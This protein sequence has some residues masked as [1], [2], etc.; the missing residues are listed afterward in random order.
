MLV[1]FVQYLTRVLSRLYTIQKTSGMVHAL[2]DAGSD[3]RD[4]GLRSLLPN[5]ALLLAQGANPS[6]ELSDASSPS[7]PTIH[8][9]MSFLLEHTLLLLQQ[10]VQ[11]HVTRLQQLQQF[12]LRQVVQAPQQAF[13]QPYPYSYPYAQQPPYGHEAASASSQP[14]VHPGAIR[15]AKLL[16]QYRERIAHL[17][18]LLH[19]YLTL[20][21][22]PQQDPQPPSLPHMPPPHAP[23][24]TSRLVTHLLQ[25]LDEMAQSLG[26]HARDFRRF[27][28]H[29]REQHAQQQ[30]QHALMQH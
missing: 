25:Q 29:T 22:Q 20:L 5:A 18:E 11:Q 26:E 24:R 7:I 30:Q 9:L 13:Q 2:D 17:S 3:A 15:A 27:L 14:V 6:G 21:A 10:H 16:E 28:Q 1:D 4:T 12:Y 8:R 23:V 19:R